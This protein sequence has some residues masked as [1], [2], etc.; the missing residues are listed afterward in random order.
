MRFRGPRLLA[1]FQYK[2][3]YTKKKKKKK[4]SEGETEAAW[5]GTKAGDLGDKEAGPCNNSV[6]VHRYSP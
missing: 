4:S 2:G 6:P 5:E 3:F 1:T